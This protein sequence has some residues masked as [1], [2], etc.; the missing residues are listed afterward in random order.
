MLRIAFAE[1]QGLNGLDDGAGMNLCPLFSA[2]QR[3]R[4]APTM[5][6]F[7]ADMEQ[8]TPKQ[9]PPIRPLYLMRASGIVFDRPSKDNKALDLDASRLGQADQGR[10][11]DPSTANVETLGLEWRPTASVVKLAEDRL[12]EWG[13]THNVPDLHAACLLFLSCHG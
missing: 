7:G 3:R 4:R 2:V 10:S 12:S 8:S 9:A 11:R 6:E 5:H 13:A 1:L